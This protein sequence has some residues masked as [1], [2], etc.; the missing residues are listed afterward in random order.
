ML[1]HKN[2]GISASGLIASSG[3]KKKY[4]IGDQGILIFMMILGRFTLH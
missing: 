2:R 1:Q 4:L 3:G